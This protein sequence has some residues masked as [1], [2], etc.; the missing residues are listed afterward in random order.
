MMG[1]E[2]LEWK[3]IKEQKKTI[4]GGEDQENDSHYIELLAAFAAYD[5]FNSEETELTS[6]KDEQKIQY[7]YRTFEDNG[8]MDFIDF[9][10]SLRKEEL[11]MKFGL[12]TVLSYLTLLD[13]YDIFGQAQS[14]D[15]K[16]VKIQGYE[17]IDPEEVK[18]LKI[19]FGLY[20]FQ[21]KDGVLIEGWLR[22]LHRSAGGGD[23]FLFH[24]GVF[25]CNTI[26][27]FEKFDFNDT[28]YKKGSDFESKKFSKGLSSTYAKFFNEFIKTAEPDIVNTC[29]KFTKRA[30][31]TL[32]K[33]YK[34]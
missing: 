17:D 3:P 24:P 13:N 12:F 27:Q 5:F 10:G 32:C 29:E 30:Y 20:H 34:F 16:K 21:M 28:I 7:L 19:Y 33:L 11:A 15:L 2:T 6:L 23:N 22:Q 31:D 1:T 4:T 18:N 14:G 25:G 9:V 26:K 8:K